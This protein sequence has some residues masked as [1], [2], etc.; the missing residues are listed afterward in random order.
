MFVYFDDVLHLSKDSQEYML[1]LN[2]VYWL[3]E[4]FGTPYIYIG[5][6]VDKFQLEDGITVWYMTFVEYLCG[7]INNVYSIL[8]GNKAALNSFGGGHCPY[9]S[10]YRK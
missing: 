7:S 9:T 1:K 10:S 4:V 3:K 8:E 6:N 2:Q 5:A